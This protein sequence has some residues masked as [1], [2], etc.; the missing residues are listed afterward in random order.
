[1]IYRW[2]AVDVRCGRRVWNNG[3]PDN[4]EHIVGYRHDRTRHVQ[5]VTLT[6]LA[7]GS[8]IHEE[9]TT[10]AMAEYFNECGHRPDRVSLPDFE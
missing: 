6:S 5:T 10:A 9:D 2:E 3:R 7:D 4:G 1:M 8:M